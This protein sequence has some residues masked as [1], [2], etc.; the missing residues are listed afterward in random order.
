M[1]SPQVEPARQPQLPKP[2]LSLD[3]QIAGGREPREGLGEGV[4][5]G[6]ELE[7]AA[8]GCVGDTEARGVGVD[9]PG[10]EVWG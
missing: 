6:D 2:G 5:P 4:V 1:A 8:V 10:E 9:E 7:R 3:D